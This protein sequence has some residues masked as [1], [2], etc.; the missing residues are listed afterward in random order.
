MNKKVLFSTLLALTC[1]LVLSLSTVSMAAPLCNPQASA[2]Q[3]VNPADYNVLI[4]AD[5]RILIMMAALNLAGYDY[6]TNGKLQGLRAQ[7]RE[8]LKSTP[9]EL[10]TK[11]RD[12]YSAHK[13]PGREEIAQV[14]PYIGLAL[15][16]SGPPNFN[17]PGVVDKLPPDVRE[18][19]DFV[20][21]LREFYYKSPVQGLLPKYKET[22]TKL[23]LDYQTTAGK[24]LFET[25]NYLHTQPLLVLPPTPL[26]SPDDDIPGEENHQKD[27]DKNQPKTKGD[28]NDKTKGQQT[29]QTR[30][31]RL[32]IIVNP[33]AASGAVF[34][35]NDIANGAEA[36][37]HR[38]GDDYFI[39]A[40]EESV[41]EHIRQGFL[42]FV[43]DPIV[44]KQS[45]EI[46]NLKESLEPLIA[47]LPK[48]SQRIRRN[49]YELVGESLARAVGTRLT[50]RA[51]NGNFTADDATY[52]MSQYYQQGAVLVY[53]FYDTMLVLERAGVDI[54][55]L[56]TSL[57]TN[58]D[59]AKE[60]K[61]MEAV[62]AAKARLEERR[63]TVSPI[64]K[65]FIEIDELIQQRQYPQ[66][67]SKLADIL[68][69][70]PK[71]ARALFAMA[72]VINNQLS[73]PELDDKADD[74]EKI[75]A[76]E[77]RLAKSVQ[78]YR[79]AIGASGTDEQWIVSQSHLFIARILDF[80]QR[81]DLALK[82]YEQVIQLGDIPKGAYKEA[83][84]G[85][86]HPY[87]PK[88]GGK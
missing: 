80:V 70:Q 28:K 8:D 23:K 79:S 38:I 57:L 41:T 58:I 85:K 31:R 37:L 60:A 4:I 52:S 62:P 29:L 84:E 7:L 64:I 56:F 49:V 67:Q 74:D 27:K 82:E 75:A 11:L 73:Q 87:T 63:T 61:R 14:S 18:V 3:S 77:E 55:D 2:P 81:R 42:R 66:A 33:L 12:Y 36:V 30:L 39:V 50:V 45:V 20:P 72:Q 78:F 88:S 17:T 69:D 40:S 53:H 47:T 86:N 76:Q 46:A 15:A 26:F 35:R 6:E 71:N 51:S 9:P 48:A 13:S 59:F 16:L 25:L 54:R 43:L 24:V 44:G 22:L 5:E 32:V 10:V 68:K 1:V 83:L 65:S 34:S 19:V 21:L